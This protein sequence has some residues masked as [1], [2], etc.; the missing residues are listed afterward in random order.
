VKR[1]IWPA[2]HRIP[3][4]PTRRCGTTIFEVAVSAVV[5]GAVVTTAAQLVQWSV[6]LHQAAL[7]KRCALEAAT[8]VLDRIS[9]RE[10][11]AI[12][13][14]S[15]KDASLPP[16]VKEFLGDARLT[17]TVTDESSQPRGKQISAEVTWPDHL[18]ARTQQ[19]RLTT[20]VF[21]PGVAK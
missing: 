12:T 17:I 3:A 2:A 19:V 11:A 14:Q 16:E 20:W 6:R 8:S 21:Q 18:G 5:L 4:S 9:A 7:K 15:A 1:G 13:P 10:W